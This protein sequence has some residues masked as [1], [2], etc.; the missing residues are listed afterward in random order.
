[1]ENQTQTKF[2]SSKEFRPIWDTLPSGTIVWKIKI[3]NGN[4]GNLSSIEYTLDA[5]DLEDMEAVSDGYYYETH[6]MTK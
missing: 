5:N 3:F 6:K 4:T 1:M 2:E